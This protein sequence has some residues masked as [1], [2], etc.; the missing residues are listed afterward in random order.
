M[1]KFITLLSVVLAAQQVSGQAAEWSQCGGI[2]WTGATICQSDL[3]C[4]YVNDYYSQ[5]TKDGSQAPP[6]IPP[7]PTTQPSVPPSPTAQPPIPTRGL[8][9]WFVAHG[10]KFWGTCVDTSTLNLSKNI[11]ILREDFGAITLESSMKWDAIEASRGSFTFTAA[12]VVV[13]WATSNGFLLPSWVSSIGDRT[14]LTAIIQNHIN[15]VAGRYKGKIYSVSSFAKKH[16]APLPSQHPSEIFNEDGSLRPSVFSQV[17]GGDS[18]VNLA[19]QT[20]RAADPHAMQVQG[21]IRLVQKV[22]GGGT[23][24]ID[25]LGTQM[26]LDQGGTGGV[27]AAINALAATGLDVAITE[28]DIAGASP[29][30]YTAVVRACLNQ[31]RCV[32]ITSWGISDS[33]SWRASSRPLLW[34]S[35][36]RPKPAYTAI[37]NL[38]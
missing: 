15:A 9:A 22:N 34:D 36:Y 11:A 10:K 20:A 19:F 3:I 31:P 27:S 4:R 30:D 28:L 12:D 23:R 13:N 8:N 14:T 38:G 17:F 35:Q 32:S 18:F 21:L 26:H 5:C 24:L 37:L 7:S 29:T 33:N 2:G 6:S 25:G 16:F 1:N